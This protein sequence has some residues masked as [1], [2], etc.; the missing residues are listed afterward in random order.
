MPESPRYF[1]VSEADALIP[2]LDAAMARLDALRERIRASNDRLHVLD[3]L[4]GER[5]AERDNPDHAEALTH[6]QA[7]PTLIHQIELTIQREMLDHG[8]RFPPGGLE[9][10]LADFPTRWQGREV[11]L[12]WQ[13]G[14]P[15]IQAW[16]E[17][18]AGFAG[19]QLLTP[20]QRDGMG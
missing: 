18:D 7:I 19:R 10:G 11:F 6:Q 20:R 12:C 1:T 5:I 3:L 8:V 4:W 2:T 14:E 15:T 16:H 9:N 17:V 13:R